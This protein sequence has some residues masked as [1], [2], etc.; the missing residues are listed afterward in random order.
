MV[1]I[2]GSFVIPSSAIISPSL[3]SQEQKVYLSKLNIILVQIVKHEWPRNWPTFIS[4]IVGSSKTN[5]SLCQNNMS[6]LKLLR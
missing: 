1:I 3:H 6:I 5:K 4:D 2:Y